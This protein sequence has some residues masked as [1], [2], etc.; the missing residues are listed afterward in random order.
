MIL[1][2]F[3]RVRESLRPCPS[4]KKT[5]GRDRDYLSEGSHKD[6]VSYGNGC[7]TDDHF[8]EQVI[9]MLLKYER[10]CAEDKNCSEEKAAEIRNFIDNDNRRIR[11]DM[12]AREK[13]G[14]VFNSTEN[15]T[16]TGE[17]GEATLATAT[18]DPLE[19][20]IR[21]EYSKEHEKV[22]ERLRISLNN[23]SAKDREIILTIYGC[24]P[25][26]ANVK[27]AAEQLGM[28]RTTVSDRHK[29]ILEAIRNDLQNLLD[30]IED[31]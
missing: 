11:R 9:D 23:L 17:R 8:S 7:V 12:S 5:G 14:V 16:E 2:A 10:A 22:L 15:L 21:Q 28:K 26:K 3:F 1:C 18:E 31:E 6:Q 29:K 25:K 13:Y 20:I 19:I 30:D 27:K 24:D 4:V